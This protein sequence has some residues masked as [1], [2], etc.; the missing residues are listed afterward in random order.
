M[1]HPLAD[2]VV[3][4]R[5]AE[6]ENIPEAAS[7][8][9]LPPAAG[10]ATR[11]LTPDPHSSAAQTSYP[12]RFSRAFTM[13]LPSQL[14]HLRNPRRTPSTWNSTST[15]IVEHAPGHSHFHEVSLE[16]ADSVQTVVQMLLQVSPH[17]LL[18]PVKE[19][20]SACSL[21][22]P[23]PSVSAMLTSMK[24]LNYISANMANF[25]T[26]SLESGSGS[27]VLL[28]SVT[29]NDFDIGEMLQSV[30]DVLSGSASQ[31]GSDLV[32]F[33]GDVAMKHVSVRG[34]ENGVSFALSHV[35]SHA[36]VHRSS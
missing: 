4:P 35:S 20:F 36:T 9:E 32:L 25:C 11:A 19:Q 27:S 2:H 24:N 28:P 18:D 16:L 13:P 12:A 30:G 10:E 1:G 22:I 7:P 33:H 8:T 14:R 23:T 15:P 6:P 31:V 21:S 17:Q 34:D 5:S 26:D 29:H 3:R